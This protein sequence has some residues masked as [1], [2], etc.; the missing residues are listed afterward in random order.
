MPGRPGQHGD[1]VRE[2]SALGC[3]HRSRS[4]RISEQFLQNDKVFVNGRLQE[5][6]KDLGH[7][8]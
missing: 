8:E 7:Y 1:Q 6:P 2:Q 4:G 5:L 3:H